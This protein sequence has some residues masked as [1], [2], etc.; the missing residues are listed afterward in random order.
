[1]RRLLELGQYV[2][3]LF[4]ER[5]REV[6]IEVSVGTKGDCYDN[7]VVEAFFASL[8]NE[9]V[10]RRSFR[11]RQEAR[12]AI[13]DYIERFY[14]PIRRHSTLDYLSPPEYERMKEERAEAA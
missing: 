12:T 14:N 9:L 13:F 10:A 5:C 7:A 1:L 11:S 4:G 2:S 3:L 6:G 8:K